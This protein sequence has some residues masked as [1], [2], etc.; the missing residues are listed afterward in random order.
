M[1]FAEQIVQDL[2]PVAYK[3]GAWWIASRRKE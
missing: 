3:R 1:K 2:F